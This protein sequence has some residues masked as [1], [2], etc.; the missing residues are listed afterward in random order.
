MAV[1]SKLARGAGRPLKVAIELLV[2]APRRGEL[3]IAL[4]RV[5]GRAGRERWVIPSDELGPDELV[6]EAA[7]RLARRILGER[8]AFLDQIVALG[9]AGRPVDSIT[10]SQ[11]GIVYL[12]LVPE[13]SAPL[14]G[15]L[16]WKPLSQVP[17]LSARNRQALE[18]TLVA[19]R[20]RV[21]QQPVA[22]R[23]L[24]AAF[25]LTELQSIYELLLGRP[26]HKASF[27]RSLHAS[28]LVEATDE[29]RSEGRGRPA[30]LFRYAASRRRRPRRGVRFDLL[31]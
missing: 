10:T 14:T 18:R 1:R 3:A 30:Q 15:E 24:P 11:I 20:R 8:P 22:F 7:V 21:D 19:I 28:A 13:S 31:G 29:W 17:P 25:T 16:T 9:G 4:E 23:L 6:D 27:R 5:V 2:V 26:L 12:G